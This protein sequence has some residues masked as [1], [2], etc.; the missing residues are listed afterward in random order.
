VVAQG[1]EV[2]VAQGLEVAAVV[3][4]GDAVGQLQVILFSDWILKAFNFILYL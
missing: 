3:A 2:V 4:V 1:L